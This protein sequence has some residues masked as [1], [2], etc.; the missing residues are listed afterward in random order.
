MTIDM[1]SIQKLSSLHISKYVYVPVPTQKVKPYEIK[2]LNRICIGVLKGLLW[3]QK[4]C[5]DFFSKGVSKA[6]TN[7][8]LFCVTVYQALIFRDQTKPLPSLNDKRLH[9]IFGALIYASLLINAKETPKL[10]YESNN[11]ETI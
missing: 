7:Q 6:T 3:E 8:C 10:N 5:E 1:E 11:E 9:N 2:I 4:P